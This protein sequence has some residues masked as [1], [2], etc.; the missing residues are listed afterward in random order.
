MNDVVF[1]MA[2]SRLE[3]QKEVRKTED[4]NID[5][6]ASDDEWTVEEIEANSN[7]NALD[8]D[9]LIEIGENEVEEACNK[10]GGT[11][12][13]DDLEVPPIAENDEDHGDDLN[14]NEDHM[15]E[16]DDYPEFNMKDFLG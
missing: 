8:E 15:G 11:T 6:L 16:E 14:E 12:P 10:G 5:D 4:Y 13:L 1:V 9:I 2:N 3:K 7:L